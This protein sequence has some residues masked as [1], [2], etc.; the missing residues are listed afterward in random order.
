MEESHSTCTIRTNVDHAENL[1]I[2]YIFFAAETFVAGAGQ[3]ASEEGAL[4]QKLNGQPLI[5]AAAAY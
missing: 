3:W 5:S 2:R 4:F 1:T